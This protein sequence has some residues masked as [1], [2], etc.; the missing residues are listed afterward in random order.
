MATNLEQIKFQYFSANIYNSV[1]LGFVDLKTF[2]R[3]NKEPR[4][5]IKT[6]FKQIEEAERVGDMKL[7]AKLKQE[8]LVYFTPCCV[9]DGNRDYSKI[10]NFTSLCILDFDH[11]D[12]AEEFKQFI[13]NSCSFIVACWLSPSRK[14]IKCL[15]KFPDDIRTIETFK[16]YFFGLSY[17]MSK[18]QGFDTSSANCSLPLFL[19]WDENLLYRDNPTTWTQKGKKIN[20]FDYKSEVEVTFEGKRT[21]YEKNIVK[22]KIRTMIEGIEDNGHPV[23]RSSSIL[24]GGYCAFGYL[25]EQEAKELIYQLI[26]EN[27]YTCQKANTYKKTVDKFLIDGMKRPLELD[28]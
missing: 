23:I 20:E 8:N 12:N 17:Y 10:L 26:D 5:N 4:E 13:F 7:K 22:K 6:V 27:S 15:V 9:F 28:M 18:Y 25:T 21:E 1:P 16:S 11:I 24:C 2:I 19:S 3:A 14:G